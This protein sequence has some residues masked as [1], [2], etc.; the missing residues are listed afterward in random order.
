MSLRDN[1]R[2][3][4]PFGKAVSF[5]SRSRA[6]LTPNGVGTMPFQR[7]QDDSSAEAW[8]RFR[9]YMLFPGKA[10]AGSW[11]TSCNEASRRTWVVEIMGGLLA[12]I[13][14]IVLNVTYAGVIMSTPELRPYL[15]YG[16][17]MCLGCT[18]LSNL[19]LLVMRR[20]LPYICVADSF[21]AVLFATTAS[22]LARLAPD[23]TAVLGTLMIAMLLCSLLLSLSYIAT[24][25]L[26][27]CNVV[28]FMPSP[29]M[30]GYQ[31]SIGYLVVDSAAK[32][33][34]GCSKLFGNACRVAE[35]S[36][37][38]WMATQLALAMGL[39]VFLSVV[40]NTG[41]LGG[42]SRILVLPTIL[43]LA[44]I[45]FQVARLLEPW[46][47]ADLALWTM[48]LPAENGFFAS[49]RTLPTDIDFSNISWRLAGSEALLAAVT[50][51]VPNIMGKLLQYSALE[52]RFDKDLDYNREMRHAG[53]SQLASAPA[54]MVPTVTY[55]G[56]LVAWDM[57]ARSF[58]P[59]AMVVISSIVLVL[60]GSNQVAVMP[61]FMFA[62]LL[63]SIGINMI[64]DNLRSAWNM[65]PV[66]EFSLVI[67]HIILTALLGMLWAVVLGVLFTAT[68]FIVEYSAHSGVLLC[69]TL[70]LERSK[71]QRSSSET[72]IL[73]Q[74]GATV[75]IVHLHGMIFFGSASSVL[76][77]IKAHVVTLAELQLP[78]Q[79]LL[80]D[81]DR[82]TGIDSSAVAVLFQTRRYI[83]DARLIFACAGETVHSSLNK[84]APDER[85]FKHFTTLDLALEQCEN[86]LLLRY[87]H[88]HRELQA[89]RFLVRV[90]GGEGDADEDDDDDRAKRVTFPT[91][92]SSDDEYLQTEESTWTGEHI[93][94][95]RR[96]HVRQFDY[97]ALERLPSAGEL[98]T[99]FVG[100]HEG[101]PAHYRCL[102]PVSS[103]ASTAP[104]PPPPLGAAAGA[105]GPSAAGSKISEGA[106]D[107]H[108]GSG[109]ATIYS[110]GQA[111]AELRPESLARMRE[112]FSEAMLSA[113]GSS[114]NVDDLFEYF[115]IMIIPP[116]YTVV[117]AAPTGINVAPAPDG[118]LPP[119]LYIIDSG[120][121]SAFYTTV[122]DE[123]PSRSGGDGNPR[124]RLAKYGPGAILGVASFVTPD[125]MPSLTM[126]PTAFISDE[127]TQLLRLPRSRCDELEKLAPGLIFRLYRLLVLVSERRL[128]EHRLRVVAS[129]AFKVNVRPS[130]NFQRIL[131]SS[132]TG[133]H[134]SSRKRLKSKLVRMASAA[135]DRLYGGISSSAS[136]ST[137]LSA[138][139]TER[140]P[141]SCSIIELRQT[142]SAR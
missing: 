63:V 71:V 82:C 47:G 44:T 89:H 84:G 79:V 64:W 123:Q 75:L 24:G 16:I 39:G 73:E 49:M 107:S 33:A 115:D 13:V 40:Q 86:R 76:E 108:T 4:T 31:A 19:W 114:F 20:N 110:P 38:H 25:V 136:F 98:A 112:R 139:H 138:E 77:E 23:G 131:I 17:A 26:R 30:F 81:F 94:M 93:L 18:A 32:L 109:M 130:T 116:H 67:L 117:S 127:Y 105:V 102:R 80:L 96:R 42:F 72:E 6:S 59:P 9:G 101:Q 99:V 11:S 124:H 43:V 104:P 126:M 62:A 53:F 34:V 54:I 35:G 121:V 58:V 48:Q 78:L 7:L 118:S 37:E 52:S 135:K 106:S 69:T 100:E 83:K 56:M 8:W 29:V 92:H 132:S 119:Y 22:D 1:E 113:Y 125:D 88:E 27:V 87:M 57:G 134:V 142:V 97:P 12:S 103:E 137:T 3:P 133:G 70:L 141:S 111:R 74:Y 55:T 28:Q 21:M 129:E 36:L 61:N 51:F 60:T 46:H 10:A 122:S 66:R 120:Y 68:I 41:L 140:R 95:A 65:L 50:A 85:E 14:A 128:Q 2:W 90:E 45:L 15:S 91:F 5:G